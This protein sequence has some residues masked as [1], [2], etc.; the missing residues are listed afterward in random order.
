MKSA[1]LWLA[2]A[3]VA[4]LVGGLAFAFAGDRAEAS[5]AHDPVGFHAGD[6]PAAVLAAAHA[7]LPQQPEY[8][9]SRSGCMRCHIRE[10]RSWDDTPHASAYE[11]LPEESRSDPDCLRCHVTGWSAESGFQSIEETPQLA[12]VGCEVC[13]GAGSLYKDREIMEDREASIANGML[14]P[15]EQTCRSCHNEESPT[16]P[17]SFDYEAGLEA[18]VHEISR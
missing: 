16:F 6:Y 15:D 7:A 2:M 9:G 4:L 12:G 3:L 13:H 1:R 17:G 11:T 18:G 5:P 14:I 8:E 10:Y